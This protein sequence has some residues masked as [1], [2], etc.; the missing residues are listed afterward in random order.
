MSINLNMNKFLFILCLLFTTTIAQAQLKWTTIGI[1]GLT[2]SQCFYSVEQSIRNIRSVQQV[3]MN[4]NDSEARVTQKID[5]YSQILQLGEQVNNAGFTVRFL[6]ITLK[7]DSTFDIAASKINSRIGSLLLLDNTVIQIDSVYTFQIIDKR[8]CKKN[9]YK[10]WW[11][12]INSYPLEDK[13]NQNNLFVIVASP[14][15]NH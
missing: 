14:S 6:T 15:K 12:V 13:K 2:C 10:R 1:D 8:Y 7:I 11:A 3:E 5:G 4:L 9:T